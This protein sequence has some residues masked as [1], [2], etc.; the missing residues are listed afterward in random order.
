MSNLGFPFTAVGVLPPVYV[1]LPTGEAWLGASSLFPF[2][3]VLLEGGL[4]WPKT[5]YRL[6]GIECFGL[7]FIAVGVLP[8]LCLPGCPLTHPAP[9][10][11]PSPSVHPPLETCSWLTGGF[12][13]LRPAL[14]FLV[15]VVAMG[16]GCRVHSVAM[17]S[18]RRIYSVWVLLS[19]C[20]LGSPLP[21][22]RRAKSWICD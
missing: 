10:L 16:Y 7:P 18:G 21:P 6:R 8:P 3:L 1:W 15:L 13:A 9:Y 19:V 20:W 2:L 22:F 12:I 17:G 14:L 4:H 11:L 5:G